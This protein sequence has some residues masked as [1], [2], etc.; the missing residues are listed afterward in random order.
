LAGALGGAAF[1]V[2]GGVKLGG[3]LEG[4]LSDEDAREVERVARTVGVKTG[5]DAAEL[6][7]EKKE[8]LVEELNAVRTKSRA[9]R[10]G[11]TKKA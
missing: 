1:G 7:P 2:F 10:G 3:W 5:P 11:G 6:P 9:K 8:Q 4:N